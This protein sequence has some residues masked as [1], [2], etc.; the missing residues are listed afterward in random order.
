MHRLHYIA[1]TSDAGQVKKGTKR[2]RNRITR[3]PRQPSEQ[4]PDIARGLDAFDGEYFT[5]QGLQSL[6]D[7]D[8]FVVQFHDG[9]HGSDYGNGYDLEDGYDYMMESPPEFLPD[10]EEAIIPRVKQGSP[11]RGHGYDD[12]GHDD[13]GPAEA[14]HVKSG[15]DLNPMGPLTIREPIVIRPRKRRRPIHVDEELVD[16]DMLFMNASRQEQDHLLRRSFETRTPEARECRLASFPVP[17][18]DMCG[19]PAAHSEALDDSALLDVLG[20]MLVHRNKTP[21]SNG[22]QVALGVA[23]DWNGVDDH[24]DRQA[25]RHPHEDLG[26]DF[27]DGDDTERGV[28]LEQLRTAL[29]LTPQNQNPFGFGPG[30]YSSNPTS[31]LAGSV[32]SSVDLSR[33]DSGLA[34]SVQKEKLSDLLLE[35]QYELQNDNG[36]DSGR[37]RSGRS[38]RSSRGWDVTTWSQLERFRLQETCV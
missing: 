1:D 12:Y 25:E 24:E 16:P 14:R 22:R 17:L 2:R 5:G 35:S 30:A 3:E 26:Q 28:E 29:H 20:G 33:E 34:N 15:V 6:E 4:A 36:P 13:Y 10:L 9:T 11:E 18:L 23:N 37:R 31:S 21:R 38:G 8:Y 27:Y 32:R 19:C 7:D